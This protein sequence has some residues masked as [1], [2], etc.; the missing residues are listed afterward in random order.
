MKN[1]IIH[2]LVI[3]VFFVISCE[4][5][6]LDT[7]TIEPNTTNAGF[8]D[9]IMNDAGAH[10][11][12]LRRGGVYSIYGSSVITNK[13]PLVIVGEEEPKAIRPALIVYVDGVE[14]T[15]PSTIIEAEGDVT[16][17]NLYLTGL[18]NPDFVNNDDKL[19]RGINFY[20]AKADELMLNVENCVCNHAAD[21][22]GFFRFNSR[23]GTALFNKNVVLNMMRKDGYMWSSFLNVNEKVDTLIFE[24][25]TFYNC[26]FVL[27]MTEHD[28]QS[29]NFF[30]FNHNTVV[31]SAKNVIPFSYGLNMYCTNNL[32]YNTLFIGNMQK[33][34]L[35]WPS[36]DYALCPDFEPHAMVTVDT[37][38]NKNYVDSVVSEMGLNHRIV[39]YRNNNFF[40]SAT[41]KAIPNEFGGDSSFIAEM[42]SPRSRA[43]FENDIEWPGFIFENNIELDPEF[44]LNPA[45]ES[46][47]LDYAKMIYRNY[48]SATNFIYDPD[49][50][51][52]TFEWPLMGKYID[53]CYSNTEVHN[54]A[55]WDHIGVYPIG[56]YYHWFT[57]E[58]DYENCISDP[59][60]TYEEHNSKTCLKVYPNP[61][62]DKVTID[63]NIKKAGNVNIAIYNNLGE[64]IQMLVNKH[65]EPGSFTIDWKPAYKV[66]GVYYCTLGSETNFRTVKIVKISE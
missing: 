6:A 56:D 36:I 49:D 28:D 15:A 32:F 39:E 61:Y 21:W 53:F 12:K 25:N 57:K 27:S 63:Y 43:M 1:N 13:F 41:V 40:Q 19:T 33:S 50:I 30:L 62:N 3:F 11:Y 51:Y 35:P 17:K 20:E 14:G 59:T 18:A 7:L 44:T 23:E 37:I 5:S 16:L 31:N 66:N 2:I 46:K 64:L 26:P 38:N 34:V 24:L 48:P 42:L 4:A 9:V 60:N 58:S 55:T 10:I 22:R 8:R 65:C 29:P 47:L 45:N 52:S 54:G